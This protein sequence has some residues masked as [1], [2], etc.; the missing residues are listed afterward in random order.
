LSHYH[1]LIIIRKTAEMSP[2]LQPQ[3]IKN[4]PIF[5]ENVMK[6]IINVSHL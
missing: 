3:S 6:T 4:T 2:V 5:S 1:K